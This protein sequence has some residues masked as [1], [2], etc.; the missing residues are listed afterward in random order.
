[1]WVYKASW[2]LCLVLWKIFF[3]QEFLERENI[4]ATGHFILAVNHTSFL[5]PV[6]AG[7]GTS[8]PD[9]H[10]LARSS[11]FAVPILGAWMKKVNVIPVNREQAD[12]KSLS[13]V[14]KTLQNGHGILMFPE[15]TRSKNGQIGAGKPGI[16]FIAYHSK[17]PVVPAYIEG[18]V[19]AL[20][21][22]SRV[23]R[24][25]KIR[26]KYGKPVQ[27]DDLYS[28]QDSREVY[29]AIS[30]RIMEK[31]KEISGQI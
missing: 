30:N 7:L 13:Q 11:L 21:R 25:V 3:R 22:H 27:L 26:T 12:R 29:Q 6:C 23:I 18:S 2:T 8:R 20:S 9:L 1:M 15:G 16:G 24:P 14:I 10:F 4:P 31:I 17:A 5:D 28:R 19:R